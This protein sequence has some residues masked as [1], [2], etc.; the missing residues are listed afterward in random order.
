MT[1]LDKCDKRYPRS[2]E[3]LC[4]PIESPHPSYE[5]LWYRVLEDRPPTSTRRTSGT[6]SRM[7]LSGDR[8]LG[9]MELCMGTFHYEYNN[10]WPSPHGKARWLDR[11]E[12]RR[13]RDAKSIIPMSSGQPAALLMRLVLGIMLRERNP[14]SPN[15]R[16]RHP[17][18]PSTPL[19]HADA[20][21]VAQRQLG[22][23]PDQRVEPVGR[24]A[25]RSPSGPKSHISSSSAGNAPTWLTRPARRAPRP[26]RR[27][28]TCRAS[29]APSCTG[30]PAST[31]RSTRAPSRRPG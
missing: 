3:A 7:E 19:Q 31:S 1:V 23:R 5:G 24:A 2:D 10:V 22:Q 17:P 12:Q 14:V 11:D 16:H 18:R 13:A 20:R 27:A 8:H 15:R 28:A 26:A 4:R 9:S 6:T 29:R 21:L 25:R 30:T